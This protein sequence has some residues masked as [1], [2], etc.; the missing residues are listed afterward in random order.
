MAGTSLKIVLKGRGGGLK[1]NEP[2]HML[3]FSRISFLNKL[4]LGLIQ[5]D[6]IFPYHS[7]VAGVR[8]QKKMI[9]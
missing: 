7:I 1:Y 4:G 3:K 9:P 8:E 5:G 2:S 6:L